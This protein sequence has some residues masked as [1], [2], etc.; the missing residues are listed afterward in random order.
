MTRMEAAMSTI[1]WHVPDEELRRYADRASTPP[2]VWSTE[3]HLAACA[4]CRE[5][6]AAAVDPES[7]RAR[8]SRL[9]TELD[10]PI[11]GLVERLLMRLGVADHTARLLAATPVLRRSWFAA[12]ASTLALTAVLAY[13]AHPVVFLAVVPL[14][15]LVGVAASFGPGVDPTY[16]IA[17]VAPMHTLR[18]L[19]LRCAAVL[20]TTT[21]LSAVAT[22]ALPRY[23]LMAL[24][25][26]LPALALTLSSLALTPR[27]GPILAAESVGLGWLALVATT[28]RSGAGGSVVFTPIGQLA[29]AVT[30]VLA[31]V[32][33]VRLRPA[34]ESPHH[35]NHIP[36]IGIRRIP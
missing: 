33:L 13:L 25:W 12:V 8:W 10:A 23:G 29:L 22:L 15:P 24:G 31:A 1:E 27:L 18:L 34:F 9:D 11:P 7:A 19:L 3:A 2:S 35:T 28:L 21:A 14:L 20:T 26:F 16:E 6:L 17:V 5:R 36:R 30:G 32:V 4:G